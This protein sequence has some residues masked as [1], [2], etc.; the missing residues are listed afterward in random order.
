MGCV[1][2]DPNVDRKLSM[3]S[4]PFDNNFSKVNI[5]KYD[6]YFQT[7]YTPIAKIKSMRK[8]YKEKEDFFMKS[9]GVED[10]I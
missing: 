8:T 4:K 5:S 7:F 1:A 9:S 10:N 3:S 6:D 2:S